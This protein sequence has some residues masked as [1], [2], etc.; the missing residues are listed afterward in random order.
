[1]LSQKADPG[2]LT[3]RNTTLKMEDQQTYLAVTY[4][5]KLTWKQHITQAEGKARR[6]LNIMCKLAGT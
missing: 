3:L 6:K 2:H 5:K 4:D 1:M